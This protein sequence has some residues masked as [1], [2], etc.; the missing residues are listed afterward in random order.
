M[1]IRINFKGSEM[2]KR[3]MTDI[4]EPWKSREQ[5]DRFTYEIYDQEHKDIKTEISIIDNKSTDKTLH[6]NLIRNSIEAIL[7]LQDKINTYDNLSDEDKSLIAKFKEIYYTAHPEIKVEQIP[8][9][10]KDQFFYRVGDILKSK[11][12]KVFYK[13]RDKIS[14]DL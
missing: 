9:G 3:G 7:K 14:S 4:S 1:D 5:L 2:Y 13:T 6:V 8:A 12:G 10:Y 11:E